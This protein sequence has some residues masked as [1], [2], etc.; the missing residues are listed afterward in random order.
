MVF[1]QTHKSTFFYK[2]SR[3]PHQLQAPL[4][5]PAPIAHD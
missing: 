3:V 4:E 2:V 5:V 1:R